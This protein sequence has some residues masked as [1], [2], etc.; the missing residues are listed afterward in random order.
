MTRLARLD[1]PGVLHHVIIC[2]IERR[3][4]FG[5]NLDKDNFLA[6]LETLLPET[7][8]AMLCMGAIIQSCAFFIPKRGYPSIKI[9][10]AITY[11]LCGKL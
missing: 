10:A 1:A 5:D 9:N 8:I 6:C 4:I 11:R 7:R 2:G 3:K